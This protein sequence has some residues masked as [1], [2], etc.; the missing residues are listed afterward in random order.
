MI[1]SDR[2][3]S[4]KLERTEARANAD[5]VD[6]RARLYPESG[7][8]WIEVGGAYAMFDGPESPLTQTFGLGIFEDATA[9]HLETLEAFFKE[10]GAPVFHEV[11]PMADPSLLGLLGERGYRPIELTS[12]MCR[13]LEADQ[14]VSGRQNPDIS[15]RVINE[16]EEEMWAKTSADAWA[17]EDAGLAEFMF[18]F[19]TVSAQCNGALP[20]LAERCGKPIATGML[21]IYDDV[22]ILAGASTIPGERNQGAQN[23]LLRR[24]LNFAA[25]RG[26]KLAVMG[27]AP[28]GQSQKNAQKN[29][30]QIAYTRTKWQL[31]G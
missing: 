12:I 24:R 13:E 7:A 18:N 10:R 29:G 16:G 31:V 8:A 6:T 30:F 27:A 22:C 14:P 25:S 26:C 19:G 15:A 5:F 21:F 2:S 20:Y 28:G 4:Q 11:S 1:F 17:T 3:L 23:E 9:E